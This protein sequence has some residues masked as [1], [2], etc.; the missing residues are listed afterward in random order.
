[1]DINNEFRSFA[2]KYLTNVEREIDKDIEWELS[3]TG[4]DAF[5]L[6]EAYEKLF[7]VKVN[8]VF[9]EYFHDE[10]MNL[11][12]LFRKIIRRRVKKKLTFRDLLEGIKNGY[13]GNS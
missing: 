13:L 11:F 1:M 2:S 8:I 9:H 5:E 7:N 3:I 6:L 4:D 12:F 10:G